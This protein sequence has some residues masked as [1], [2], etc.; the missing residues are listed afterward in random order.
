[1]TK[2]QTTLTTAAIG[3][4]VGI[5][6]IFMIPNKADAADCVYGDGYQMCFTITG[7][8]GPYEQWDVTVRN[9]HTTENMTVVCDDKTKTV[10]DWESQGGFSQSEADYLADAFCSL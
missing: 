2:F 9:N 5:A 6:G 7:Q 3:L 4:A 8:A 10:V 1:M